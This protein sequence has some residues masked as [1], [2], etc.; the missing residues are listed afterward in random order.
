ME[1]SF[2]FASPLVCTVL[3]STF[4]A[5]PSQVHADSDDAMRYVV[6]EWHERLPLIA[7]GHGQLMQYYRAERPRA[8]TE[9]RLPLAVAV[10]DATRHPSEVLQNYDDA[11]SAAH[12]G[13]ALEGVARYCQTLR[14]A[15]KPGQFT[16]VPVL[17]IA[18][19]GSADARFAKVATHLLADHSE[20]E[21][22]QGFRE[23]GTY[24]PN[25]DPVLVYRSLSKDWTSFAKELESGLSG[26]RKRWATVGNTKTRRHLLDTLERQTPLT[27]N[28]F[29]LMAKNPGRS[30]EFYLLERLQALC[31]LADR[32]EDENGAFPGLDM[33][34]AL[35]PFVPITRSFGETL[36]DIGRRIECA[37][38]PLGTAERTR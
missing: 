19:I 15:V 12:R 1:R 35:L 2:R 14:D 22:C 30:E 21:P 18:T 37:R 23:A 8:G 36:E 13:A 34:L 10:R 20:A 25:D 33:P 4:L 6:Y 11:P 5:S 9:S 32:I 31:T 26:A 3:L 38:D 29:A 7:K 28:A 27:S 24:G 17:E 16:F